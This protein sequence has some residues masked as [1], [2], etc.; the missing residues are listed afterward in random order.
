MVMT[1]DEAAAVGMVTDNLAP[2]AT[3]AEEVEVGPVATTNPSDPEEHQEQATKI[4]IDMGAVDD[5]ETMIT[6]PGRD[7]TTAIFTTTH[8]TS[9]DTECSTRKKFRFVGRAFFLQ[10]DALLSTSSAGLLLP[11]LRQLLLG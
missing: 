8:E 4:A 10:L 3:A 9:G 5:P 1:F 7:T 2:V 11:S 6:D